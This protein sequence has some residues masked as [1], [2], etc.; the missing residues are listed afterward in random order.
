V[1]AGAGLVSLSSQFHP[2]G[3][4]SSVTRAN[5]SE[6][7]LLDFSSQ[8][9]GP[10]QRMRPIVEKL[11]EQGLPVR[12]VD[13]DQQPELAQQFNIRLLPTFVLVVDGREVTRQV[14]PRTEAEL[15][16][17]LL[18]IPE[19]R[20]LST[21]EATWSRSGE[22]KVAQ[23]DFNEATV[24]SPFHAIALGEPSREPPP[25][26]KPKSKFPL[27]LFGGA[28]RAPAAKS[29]A[30]EPVARAQAPS[31]PSYTPGTVDPMSASVRLRVKDQGGVN[32][33]SGTVIDSRIGRTLIL[34]CG[35]LFRDLKGGAKV[36][37]DVFDRQ[38]KPATYVG[39]IVDFDLDADVGLVAIAT[40]VALPTA[41]LGT[42]N[43][44]LSVGEKVACI[45]CGGGELPLQEPLTVTALN[46]YDGPDNVEC[47]GVPVRGRSGGGL[48]CDRELIGVCV[49]A[50]PQEK[51]GLYCGLKPIYELLEHAGYSNL[52]PVGKPETAPVVASVPSSVPPSTPS[53]ALSRAFADAPFEPRD[54]VFASSPIATG[55]AVTPV[56]QRVEPLAEGLQLASDAEVICIIRPKNATEPSRVVVVHQASPKLMSYLLDSLSPSMAAP[57]PKPQSL[58]Q[59]SA[60]RAP[61]EPGP[62]RPPSARR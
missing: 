19:Q 61:A 49:A 26:E 48:F 39:S 7:V 17:M 33:G 28:K 57:E 32:F 14:G 12:L 2:L 23:A 22:D 62:R 6:G 5:L 58:I 30:D 40:T 44:S 13:V 15:R 21:R 56:T 47:T 16:R 37:V 9:C 1:L 18:Q 50:D 51:R 42:I 11:E 59:T 24:T 43:R 36:E 29:D 34:T 55:V 27:S 20:E 52:L 3:G 4:A 41:P 45:G 31:E 10:C 35:H 53:S 46:K 25:A 38:R 54:D 60:T 8:N